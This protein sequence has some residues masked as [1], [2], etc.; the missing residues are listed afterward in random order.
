MND[1]D[2]NNNHDLITMIKILKEAVLSLRV[3][4]LPESITYFS[5][6]NEQKSTLSGQ[7]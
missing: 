2:N 3:F 1:N 4:T 7:S 6:Q 5:I